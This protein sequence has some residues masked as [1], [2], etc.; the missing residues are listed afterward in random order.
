M[1]LKALGNL[2]A[3]PETSYY[4]ESPIGQTAGLTK[5]ELF[6]ALILAGLHAN[7]ELLGNANG[8]EIILVAVQQA[9][10]LVKELA[11]VDREAA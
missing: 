5:R 6:S 4:D 1:D 8:P 9:D 2:P 10:A 11:K 3:F 7:P